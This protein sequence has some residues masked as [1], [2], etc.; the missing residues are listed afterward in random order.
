[1][2]CINELHYLKL[3][4]VGAEDK[5]VNPSKNVDLAS[6]P[7]CRKS[8]EQHIRRVNF[9]VGIWK[10]ANVPNPTIPAPTD[11]NGWTLVDGKLEPLWFDCDPLP[12]SL[13]DVS[14]RCDT[15]DDE[16]S[17]LDDSDDGMEYENH[18]QS[19]QDSD[20]DA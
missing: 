20:S 7:P 16:D 10:H 15:E 4:E 2:K 13:A 14:Q 18:E 9:Q 6:V 5:Q 3:S 1:M 12:E 19:C 17:D 8:L 11:N